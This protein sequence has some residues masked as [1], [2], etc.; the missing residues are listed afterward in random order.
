VLRYLRVAQIVAQIPPTAKNVAKMPKT[1]LGTSTD[2]VS[3]LNY[4][5]YRSDC[6][7]LYL[8]LALLG[9]SYC[10]NSKKMGEREGTGSVRLSTFRV[11]N[12]LMSE[13]RKTGC[14][15]SARPIAPGPLAVKAA[16]GLPA[17]LHGSHTGQPGCSSKCSSCSCCSACFS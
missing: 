14:G 3:K 17:T 2:T 6:E 12:L 5:F 7:S 8:P 10:V 4:I 11:V 9:L 1:V 13:S 16:G 15:R